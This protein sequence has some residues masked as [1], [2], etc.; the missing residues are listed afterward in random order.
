MIS[1][2]FGHFLDGRFSPVIRR[3]PLNPNALTL[4]GFLTSIWGAYVLSYN[5]QAG[6]LLVLIG[7]TFDMM[8]G[9]VARINGKV[10]PF[11][12]YLD[13]VL[14]RYSDGFQFLGIAYFLRS[15]NHIGVFMALGTMLGAFLVS[16]A[17]ARAEGLGVPCTVGIMERP[18]RIVLIAL[19]ALTG[20]MVPALWVMFVLTHFT[21]L[22]RIFYTKRILNGWNQKP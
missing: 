5:L 1:A 15:E 6:G 10:T 9:M 11:G 21:A 4:T 16:Y 22:Q 12:A 19:G 7:G 17:R 18:E 20:Y 8:D 3:I 2:R 13:S 14:D